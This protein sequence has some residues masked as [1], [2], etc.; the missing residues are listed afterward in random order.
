MAHG[1]GFFIETEDGIKETGFFKNIYVE[2]QNAE[3]AEFL[4]LDILKADERLADD[5]IRQRSPD[6]RI[7]FEDIDEY[8]T[9][10]TDL[11]NSGFIFYDPNAEDE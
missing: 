10:P 9:A 11:N 4:A 7:V 8:R 5:S 6:A 3:G 2:A 1:T